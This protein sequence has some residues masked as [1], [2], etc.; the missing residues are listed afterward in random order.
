MGNVFGSLDNSKKNVSIQQFSEPQQNQQLQ[1]EE[2]N[3][4]DIASTV[5]KE[6][7]S[8]MMRQQYP[9]LLECYH[10]NIISLISTIQFNDLEYIHLIKEI[11]SLIHLIQS[12]KF[13][14]D[15]YN[16]SLEHLISYSFEG[17]G[18]G[19]D[20]FSLKKLRDEILGSTYNS[21]QHFIIVELKK[22]IEFLHNYGFLKLE[23]QT[24]KD[25]IFENLSEI[26]NKNKTSLNII[27]LSN[28]S[29]TFLN[30]E[31]TWP[32][33]ICLPVYIILSMT[34]FCSHIPHSS[35]NMNI[36]PDNFENYVFK[37]TFHF[38]IFATNQD[39]QKYKN[40]KMGELVI[41]HLLK[42]KHFFI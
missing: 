24:H 31:N 29:I 30:A 13:L 17:Y 40:S 34:A 37:W 23:I 32:S 39:I 3:V 16:Y 33:G 8:N 27:Q 21:S 18:N 41:S 6:D 5:P 9:R 11:V 35:N 42:C 12:N 25:S 28:K 26:V 36:Y 15:W 22:F 2:M 7:K 4:D 19:P 10:Q 1:P 14:E 20:C 38:M